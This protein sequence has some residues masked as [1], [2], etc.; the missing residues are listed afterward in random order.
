MGNSS[1]GCSLLSH[2]ESLWLLV[3]FLLLTLSKGQKP[4]LGEGNLSLQQLRI[5]SSLLM[6]STLPSAASSVTPFGAG[7]VGMKEVL[8]L[9]PCPGLLSVSTAVGMWLG[10]FSRT[11][12]ALGTL[13]SKQSP[14]AVTREP[15]SMVCKQL[16]P[17]SLTKFGFYLL[18]LNYFKNAVP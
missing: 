18:L 12:M 4:L 6:C 13:G 5:T 1:C 9:N 17:H 16:Y 3:R 2:T 10:H 11:Q 7:E 14:L 8:M 15:P